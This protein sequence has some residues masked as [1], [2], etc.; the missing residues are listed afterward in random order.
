M[1]IL[2]DLMIRA[3]FALLA[4]EWAPRYGN[5]VAG[6]FEQVANGLSLAQVV[7]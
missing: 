3:T 5:V 6:L 1:K 4:I 7:I 2:P